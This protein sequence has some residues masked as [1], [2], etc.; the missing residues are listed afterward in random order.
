MTDAEAPFWGPDFAAL[1]TEDL[2]IASVVLGE[3]GP[4]RGGLQLIA[5]EN[6]TL[7]G[8][9]AALGSTLSNKYAEGYPG[10]RYYGGCAEVDKAGEP[11]SPGPRTCSPPSMRTP[12]PFGCQREHGGVCRVHRPRRHGAGHVAAARWP[13]D[14]RLQGQLLRQVVRHR[15]LRRRRADRFSTTTTRSATSPSSTGPR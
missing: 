2:E 4:L 14:P 12:T 1:Q 6:L 11:A 15:L 10:R 7:P 9:S 8:R 3:L 5:S 13:P